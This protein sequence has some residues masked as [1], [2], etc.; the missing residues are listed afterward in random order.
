MSRT[1]Q[2]TQEK[3][4]SSTSS[5]P[6]QQL[7]WWGKYLGRLSFVF[8]L[9]STWAI[10]AYQNELTESVLAITPWSATRHNGGGVLEKR[11]NPLDERGVQAVIGI[12]VFAVLNVAVIVVHHIVQKIARANN[13]YKAVEHVISPF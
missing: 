3:H 11:K 13:S 6:R 10:L 12:G 2:V 5:H 9:V 1:A 8:L 4:Y 7:S